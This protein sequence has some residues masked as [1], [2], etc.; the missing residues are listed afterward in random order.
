MG[1]VEAVDADKQLWI[2]RY[3]KEGGRAS[4]IEMQ[5]YT[6]AL[7]DRY[8]CR[9]MGLIG[10]KKVCFEIYVFFFYGERVEKC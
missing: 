5:A 9:Q 7:I 1:E 2:H 3:I 6:G 4:F 8:M 10:K